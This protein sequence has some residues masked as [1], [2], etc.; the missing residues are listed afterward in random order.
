MSM[1]FRAWSAYGLRPYNA[2]SSQGFSVDGVRGGKSSTPARRNIAG[3]R[4]PGPYQHVERPSGKSTRQFLSTAGQAPPSAER[5][6]VLGETIHR[7]A[8]PLLHPGL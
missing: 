6:E 5:L 2:I 7:L 4:K 8:R 3:G 1:G